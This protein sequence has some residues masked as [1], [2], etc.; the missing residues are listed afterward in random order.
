MSDLAI[1]RSKNPG[2]ASYLDNW[3]KKFEG[4]TF[5]FADENHQAD[6]YEAITEMAKHIAHSSKTASLK[7]VVNPDGVSTL[8]VN[9]TP[10]TSEPCAS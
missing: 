5:N 7:T 9:V 1:L 3:Q 2:L 8:Y 4:R 6:F 10:K